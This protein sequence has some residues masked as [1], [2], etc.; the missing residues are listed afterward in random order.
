MDVHAFDRVAGRL[1][2]RLPFHECFAIVFLPDSL[3]HPHFDAP[4]SPNCP[5][6]SAQAD[7]KAWSRGRSAISTCIV[8]WR[9]SLLELFSIGS[10]YGR[11]RL[12]HGPHGSSFCCY[13]GRLES[14]RSEEHSGTPPD[15]SSS[16][17]G[18][19]SGVGLYQ[20]FASYFPDRKYAADPY[21]QSYS[22]G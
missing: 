4:G 15:Q 19:L 21:F 7:A 8:F 18:S 14:A 17:W 20:L 11:C 6:I 22:A 5:G 2:S 12:K 13:A 10:Y 3:A 1:S 9:S 16:R